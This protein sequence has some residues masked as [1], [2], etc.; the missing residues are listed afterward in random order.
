MS[1]LELAERELNIKLLKI[2]L[3]DKKLKNMDDPEER[4]KNSEIQM[5]K[6]KI[7]N[8]VDSIQHLLNAVSSMTTGKK[9]TYRPAL[10]Y[11]YADRENTTSLDEIKTIYNQLEGFKN[12]IISN[13]HTLR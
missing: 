4:R 6:D 7:I 2:K 5:E 13:L 10:S 9:V 1:V 11:N 12:S 8:L 3:H